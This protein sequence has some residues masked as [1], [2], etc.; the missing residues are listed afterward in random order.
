MDQ[1]VSAC[2]AGGPYDSITEAAAILKGRTG[3]CGDYALSG[4]P[5]S[6][7]VMMASSLPVSQR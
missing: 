1:G 5:A 6:K 4:Y 3:G 2:C 7:P